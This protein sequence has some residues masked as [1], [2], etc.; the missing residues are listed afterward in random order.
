MRCPL[1]GSP[2]EDT[3]NQL[4]LLRARIVG[5]VCLSFLCA[6]VARANE[7]WVVPTLQTDTGGLGVGNGIWPVSPQGVTRL[8]VAVPDDLQTFQGAKIVLIP[9][10]PAGA[11]VLHL[12]VCTAEH[13]DMVGASC[14]G[15]IDCPFTGVV[16]QLIEVDV[17]TALA[18]SVAGPGARYMA[19]AV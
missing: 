12:H 15:P 18:P 16:N 10:A 19:V 4:R 17:F 3:M 7:I 13:S 11:G 6:T 5:L 9:K 2:C 1:P 8:V 14:V